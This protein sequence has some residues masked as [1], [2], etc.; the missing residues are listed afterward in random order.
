MHVFPDGQVAGFRLR[1]QRDQDDMPFLVSLMSSAREAERA[2]FP[3]DASHWRMLMD[4]QARAQTHHYRAAYPG[5]SMDILEHDGQGAGRLCLHQ[6][7]D[8][9]LVLDIVII[10]GLRG[11]GH[12]GAILRAV[13]DAA[14]G[15]GQA[16]RLHVIGH[17]PARRLYERLGFRTVGDDGLRL[18]MEWRALPH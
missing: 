14:A 4:Q 17:N 6:R 18:A 9:I 12:G 5:A 13:M 7:N 15:R 2:F 3:G 8:A 16:V 11:R 1:P 10:P